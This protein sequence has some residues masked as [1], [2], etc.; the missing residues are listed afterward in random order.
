MAGS[1]SD[2]QT[3]SENLSAG[4]AADSTS[5]SPTKRIDFGP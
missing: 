5:C 4:A 2:C 3:P 1:I